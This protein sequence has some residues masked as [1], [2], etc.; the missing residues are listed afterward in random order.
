MKLRLLRLRS[1]QESRNNE[2][3]KQ[4]ASKHPRIATSANW[5]AKAWWGIA[6]GELVRGYLYDPDRRRTALELLGQV[7]TGE[8]KELLQQGKGVI[9]ATAHLGPP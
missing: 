3:L 5:H 6:A 2:Q 7:D 8:L 4:W 9:I 1:F